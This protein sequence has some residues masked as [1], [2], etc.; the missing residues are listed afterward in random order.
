MKMAEAVVSYTV[1]KIGDLLIQEAVCLYDVKD[2]VE[3]LQTEL[4]RMQCF[5]EDADCKLEQDALVRNWVDEI[6]NVAYEAEDVIDNYIL[7]AAS[8]ED[9]IRRVL[10]RF[11]FTFTKFLRLYIIGSQIKCI[12]SK[13]EGI[14]KSLIKYG[15]KFSNDGERNTSINEMQRGVRKTYPQFIEDEVIPLD[16]STKNLMAQ[17][18]EDEDDRL[19]VVSIVGM[20]GLG[21]T[22]LAKKVYNHIDVKQHFDCQAWAFVSQQ[23]VTRE[24]LHGILKDTSASD[25]ERDEDLVVKLYKELLG[26][27]YL[28]VLDDIWSI[29]AWLRLRSAFPDEKMGSRILLTTRNKEVASQADPWGLLI[30][31]PLLTHDQSWEL[32][33]RK[34]FKR[35]SVEEQHCSSGFETLG[36]QIAKE[37]GGLP[38]AIVIIGGLLAQKKLITEW[39]AVQRNIDG[40]LQQQ[41]RVDG[42]HRILALSYQDLP[43]YLK[44]CFLYVGVFPE[45]SEI[46]K[47][48][49]IR[50]W[51][52]EGFIS[53]LQRVGEET[54]EDVAEHYLQELVSRCM[55]QVDKKD[56]TGRGIKTCRIHDLLRDLSVQK[57]REFNFLTTI[58]TTGSSS[59]IQHSSITQ[60]RRVSIYFNNNQERYVPLPE[61]AEYPCL[62]S[63]LYFVR[64]REMSVTG[65]GSQLYKRFMLLRVLRLDFVK[66]ASV[67]K[68]IGN[69]ILLR[70]LGLRGTEVSELP[71][72]IGNLGGL[73]TLDVRNNDSLPLPHATSKLKLL[74][75]LLYSS[76][77]ADLQKWDFHVNDLTNLETLKNFNVENLIRDNEVLGLSFLRKLG[78]TCERSEQVEKVLES[79]SVKLGRLQSLYM[80]M[81]ENNPFPENMESLSQCGNLSKLNLEGRIATGLQFL[82]HSLAKLILVDSEL[83]RDP[84]EVLETLPKLRYLCLGRDAYTGYEMVCSAHGFPQLETLEFRG[85]T[86]VEEWQVKEGSMPSLKR[87]T[88]NFMNNLKMIPE[89][90]RCV[91]TLQELNIFLMK[92]AFENRFR[93]IEGI[94]G[95]DFYKVCHIPSISFDHTID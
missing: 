93:A 73:H 61:A 40:H 82:P 37:C 15:I 45:D 71:K 44:P 85:L 12:E 56:H 87:L 52:A 66:L 26:K 80:V 78:I 75:H 41:Q 10:N 17:L 35:R 94:E 69:L 8:R 13:I 89:G 42:L 46:R 32:L 59:P 64:D 4:K 53:S 31:P 19:R 25:I 16:D 18:M 20:G 14:S 84:L 65:S 54:I 9:G 27:R 60:S 2:K 72:S 86:E 1:E 58:E 23:F 48:E 91:T 50:L 33:Q 92:R 6:R 30:E 76:T 57:G 63:L 74:R 95:D 38:L 34:A 7:T 90:L 3:Q 36:K 28:I 24:V 81:L 49:L 67:P 11:A 77:V 47:S 43:H 62:R 39:E 68:E 83:S 29:G 55:L 21:K 79:P 51:I 22:T 70:Y 5:L 88:I